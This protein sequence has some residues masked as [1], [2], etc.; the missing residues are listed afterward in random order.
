MRLLK[1]RELL[2]SEHKDW[3]RKLEVLEM[4]ILQMMGKGNSKREIM[5]TKEGT[6]EIIES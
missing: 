3:K 4:H 2:M 6:V 5:V 1:E